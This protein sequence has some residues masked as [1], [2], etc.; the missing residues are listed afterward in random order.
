MN[1]DA[2]DFFCFS[3]FWLGFCNCTKETLILVTAN[4]T[5]TDLY[6]NHQSAIYM[7]STLYIMHKP[8]ISM[9]HITL[10]LTLMPD[11]RWDGLYRVETEV[12]LLEYKHPV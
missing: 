1:N 5:V 10:T 9:H 11:V 8:L 12:Y 6:I 4:P 2:L 3:D 7:Y